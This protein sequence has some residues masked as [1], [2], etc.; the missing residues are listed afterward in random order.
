LKN[1]NTE[2]NYEEMGAVTFEQMGFLPFLNFY[3]EGKELR[4]NGTK[5]Q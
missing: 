5:H 1:I 2:T 4:N 3:Y